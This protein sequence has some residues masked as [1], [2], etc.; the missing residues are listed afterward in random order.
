M[1]IYVNIL[2]NL[3]PKSVSHCRVNYL[4]YLLIVE[5]LSDKQLR[6]LAKAIPADKLGELAT[7][8]GLKNAE[9]SHIEQD[10]PRTEE[11][12]YQV[13]LKWRNRLSRQTRQEEMDMLCTYLREAEIDA[14]VF[15]PGTCEQ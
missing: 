4:F 2:H 1:H 12:I 3:C 7:N 10:H 11:R 14:V 5:E 6:K 13:L 15:F 9:L 8:L